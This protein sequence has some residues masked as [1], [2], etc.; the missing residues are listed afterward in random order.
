[1]KRTLIAVALVAMVALAGCSALIGSDA[2]TDQPGATVTDDGV[3]LE[4]DSAGAT[5]VNQTLRLTVDETTNGSEWT[6]IGATYPRE[7]FTVDSAQHEEIILGVDTDADGESER[8]FNE[9]HVSGVNNNAYSFDATLDTDYTLSEGDVVV[10]GYP[11]VDNPDEP[12]EYEVDVRVNDAQN[13]TATV[14]IE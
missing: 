3:A 1:M 7:N 14:T 5:D 9:S 13:A 2:D 11:A 8:E 10:V 12:G 6:A 4:D